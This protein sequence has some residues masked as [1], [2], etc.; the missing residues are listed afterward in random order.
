[1]LVLFIFFYCYNGYF[2][3]FSTRRRRRLQI[4]YIRRL[5][6]VLCEFFN[7]LFLRCLYASL[8]ISVSLS[9]AAAVSGSILIS[10]FSTNIP[11]KHT[12]RFIICRRYIPTH[13]TCTSYKCGHVYNI[14]YRWELKFEHDESR[15]SDCS[16]CVRKTAN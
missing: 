9:S 4:K 11:R 1:L 12:S 13:Y 6:I 16:Y 8:Y 2:F 5:P 15:Y 7:D 3:Q 10:V 14:L